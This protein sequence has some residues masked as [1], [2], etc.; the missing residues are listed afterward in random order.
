MPLNPYSLYD[1]STAVLSGLEEY[2]VLGIP[3]SVTDLSR[4][5]GLIVDWKGDGRARSVGVREVASLMTMRED[6]K[7]RAIAT[8]TSMNLPDGMPLVWI[9]RR[10]GLD[11]GRA[12]GPDLMAKV[13][14]ESDRTGL[15]HFLYGGKP[16]IA[17]EIARRFKALL[18][19]LQIVGTYCPPF[20]EL[21]EEEDLEVVAQINAS[22]ADI[23]WVGISSPR[24]DIWMDVHLDR[25]HCTMIGVGAAFDFHS[26]QISRAP[27][28]V[29]RNGL[30][31][32]FRLASEP[33][34]LWRRYLI[35][36]PKF[37]SLLIWEAVRNRRA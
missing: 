30:E 28:W 10:K 4:A 14:L 22:K 37:V 15:T 34:R 16:G 21:T 32:L 25:L 24:Q 8:R 36:A 31:W 3:I 23:L 20:R 6:P 19:E 11:V 5:A 17:D 9:G 35:L 1:A 26:G 7:L 18:P 12:C 2:D 27:I 33:K 13:L 29:Q